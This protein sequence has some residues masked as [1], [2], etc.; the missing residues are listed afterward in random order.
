MALPWLDLF[1]P[2]EPT[3]VPAKVG[4]TEIEQVSQAAKVFDSWQGAHGGG[5]VREAMAAPLRW[6]A[7]FLHADCPQDLRPEL[8][9]AVANLCSVAGFTAF[10]AGVQ[11][12]ARRAFRFG[13]ACADQSDN[14]HVRSW[15]LYN[16][17][18]QAMYCGRLDEALTHTELAL[19]RADRLTSDEHARLH[20][21]RARV[22]AKLHRTQDA[23]AAV[24]A[25]DEIL[26]SGDGTPQ[27]AN[28]PFPY[29]HAWH[30]GLTGHAL[31]DL[32]LAG[33]KTQAENHLVYAV[34]N[35]GPVRAR[36]IA[37]TEHASLLM[38]TGDPYQGAVIGSQALD[39]AVNLM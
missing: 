29:D 8:F 4:R 16:A 26:E 9:A 32:A 33:R 13:L 2:T 18:V 24:G 22:F 21:V 28:Q 3:P 38:A 34:A 23:L 36:A 19:A 11:D 37:Q 15:L 7:Q 35:H 25:A 5:L 14:W 27:D 6:S 31:F 10:D 1:G 17:A 39:A 12:D 30:R 20:T